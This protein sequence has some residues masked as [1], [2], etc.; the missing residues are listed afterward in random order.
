M[1]KL[2]SL[3]YFILNILIFILGVIIFYNFPYKI[4]FL[5]CFGFL[6]K[7]FRILILFFFLGL[8]V[9]FIRLESLKHTKWQNLQVITIEG[10]VKKLYFKKN[11]QRAII[12]IK[13]SKEKLVASFQKKYDLRLKDEVVLTGLFIDLPQKVYP[14]FYDVELKSRFNSVIGYIKVY[15][16]KVNKRSFSFVHNSKEYILSI[17]NKFK[18]EKA[19]SIATAIVL[20][21]KGKITE[22]TYNIFKKAGIAH[23]LAIS[24]LH[25][26]VVC[27]LI[28]IFF[29]QIFSFTPI[30][31]KCDSKK[32]AALIGLCFGLF[33]LVLAGVPISGLRSF[34]MVVFAFFT[35]SF[36]IGAAGVRSLA[37]SAFI[38][39][40]IWP[41]ELFFPSFQLSFISVLCLL[42]CYNFNFQSKIFKYIFSTILS[43]FVVSFA[44]LPFVI[45]HFSFVHFYGSIS[46]IIAIPIL[47]FWI[48]PSA[49]LS[50]FNI[51]CF[52]FIFESGINY[53]IKI[54]NFVS[55]LPFSSIFM[56]NFNGYLLTSYSLCLIL[57]LCFKNKKIK[58]YALCGIVM[59]III[60]FLSSS[61]PNVV[62]NAEYTVVRNK[63][64]YISLFYIPE[65]FLK[66]VWEQ[67]LNTKFIP[68]KKAQSSHLT[69]FDGACYSF[70]TNFTILYEDIKKLAHCTNGILI[71]TV[72]NYKDFN[73]NFKRIITIKQLQERGQQPFV[74]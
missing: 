37:L 24:G 47:I 73:C 19:K 72:S 16:Y 57:F 17:L 49:L 12:K 23:I 11:S 64:Q 29:F 20:G 44:T 38:I 2:K 22:D 59:I 71:N 70:Q 31:V 48:I 5:L 62:S 50:I 41:E 32:I 28:F 35:F 60:Y 39:L 1:I 3:E 7:P 6:L 51:N 63:N 43:S 27:I 54:A 46:N 55:N 53:L 40:I 14:N 33:Y 18:S 36:G 67:K 45:H 25:M 4:L 10:T 13:N 61:K 52:I 68:I 65:G 8:L 69:C 9:M 15:E 26:T 21:D 34:L 56:L 58:S 74:L 66:N 42:H 30:C